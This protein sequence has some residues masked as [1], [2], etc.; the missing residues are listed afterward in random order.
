V[1]NEEYKVGGLTAAIIVFNKADY[2]KKP[3]AEHWL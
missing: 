1:R 2:S 3:E